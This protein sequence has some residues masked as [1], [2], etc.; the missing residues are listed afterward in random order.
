MTEKP[1][2]PR[3]ALN[4][5]E[6]V[7]AAISPRWGARRLMQKNMLA[8]AGGYT[9]ASKNHATMRNWAPGNAS[10]DDDASADLPTLRARSSDLIRNAPLAGSALNTAVLHTAGTGLSL[11]CRI[12]A[13]YL[14]LTEAEADAW[15]ANTEREFRLWAESTDCDLTRTQNFYGLQ[16]LAYRSSLE[17]GDVLALFPA[18][19]RR[20]SPYSLAVQL[21]EADRVSNPNH[22][23][24][25]DRLV[26]GVELD[27]NG[28]V[29]RYHV[30]SHYPR[31]NHYAKGATWTPVPARGAN[32]DRL[33]ALLLFRRQRPGQTR[34]IPMLAPVIEPLKQLGRYTSAELA[35]AVNASIWTVFVKMDPAAFDDLFS[36][37]SAYFDDGAA[38][39][40]LSNASRWDGSIPTTVDDPGKAVNLLPG[41]SIESPPPGRPNDQFDPFVRA[42]VAQIGS[43]LGIPFQMLLKMYDQSYTAARASFLDA[44]RFFYAERGSLS[45]D[46]CQPIYELWLDEAISLGRIRA[47]GYYADPA[48]RRA[49]SGA[50]W[51][52]DGP[53][54]IDPVKDIEAA[55]RR[56][57]LGISTRAAES[58]AHDGGDW[59]TKHRQL[60]KE[61]AARKRD[62]LT[63]A[64]PAPAS[65]S[66]DDPAP[67][68]NPPPGI[69]PGRP[70]NQRAVAMADLRRA[71][72]DA[73]NALLNLAATKH[74]AD[75]AASFA[76]AAQAPAVPPV[77]QNHVHVA[78]P[79]VHVAAPNVTVDN[80]IDPT[81]ITFEAVLPEQAAPVVNVA[82][83]NVSVTAPAVNVAA[84]NVTI[85]NAAP[86]VT[87]QPAEIREV[88]IVGMVDR[89]T[90]S[91]VT[92]DSA[93]N[94]TRTTQTER[95]AS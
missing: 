70:N 49:W 16:A 4:A 20:H 81:P 37:N 6:R 61:E 60:A 77:V 62:G 88:R 87:V 63:T 86:A 95:D 8:L 85:E 45:S 19:L 93:G 11:Q 46:F 58:I 68:T 14:G 41:E 28:A 55:S 5:L 75:S 47:P 82:A 51:V 24:N 50:Q 59:L 43:R 69:P 33:N 40:Y 10:A 91:T 44:W 52:G 21:V 48:Y 92:R 65:D 29:I 35:A 25:S 66:E 31:G 80:H 78:S 22:A 84:P 26:D 57:E 27:P 73:E 32:T 3:A 23:R 39:Q 72:L 7:G 12:D 38:G 36:S 94:I 9:G 89:Q 71:T 15:Q 56:I 67:G 79:D 34:G 17:R 90:T 53:G 1:T 30:A 64:A 54:S 83:P 18:I 42:I 76:A 74:L 2:P 13:D